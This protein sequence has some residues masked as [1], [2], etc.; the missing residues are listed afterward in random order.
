MG[1]KFSNFHTVHTVLSSSH[2]NNI[3]WNQFFDK[4]VAFTK[5]LL[6]CVRENFRNFHSVT[7]FWLLLQ[8]VQKLRILIFW[9]LHSNLIS[10]Y[11]IHS[12]YLRIQHNSTMNSKLRSGALLKVEQ[13][14]IFQPKWKF[15]LV[16]G[17]IKL[18]IAPKSA[19]FRGQ[20]LFHM[21]I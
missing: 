2:Q 6:K 5:F 16:K 10:S 21:K 9:N 20:C 13:F 12:K 4:T 11:S 1:E 19:I 17:S 8:I 3:S 14:F 7:L 15:H 18:P